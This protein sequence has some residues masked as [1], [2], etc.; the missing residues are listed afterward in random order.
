MLKP[1]VRF[2][3]GS[4]RNSWDQ[5]ADAYTRAQT[6][7]RDHYRYEFFGPA[8]LDLCGE[9]RGLSILDVGCGNGYFAR[10]LARRGARVTG[11]D[12]SPRMVEHAK[13]QEMDEPLGIEYRVL[14][15][16]ALPDGFAPRS[17]DMVTSC[18]AL[19]DMP[20]V[21]QVFRGVHT[22]L[23]PGQRFVA[24]IT[25]P[26][27]DTP[28]REWERDEKG[29]KR[30][31][32]IDRYFERGAFEYA[33]SGWGPDFVTEGFRAPLEDWLG[34]ILGAGFQLRGLKE[35]RPTDE[36]LRAHPDL[37]DAAR[38]PY[39]LFFDLV[40]PSEGEGIDR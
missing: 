19:Q 16:A 27:T 13:R 5:V 29:A 36:A 1:L 25:H 2:D 39:F 37:E 8:Q 7:G 24:S 32:C 26:C 4:V 18:M 33:W 30:W 14:D 34:W 10:A 20:R 9:V 12:I 28:Y 11:I 15:A 21:D 35:P 6:S 23:R 17:F 3:A 22:L 31:L 40:R 38:V